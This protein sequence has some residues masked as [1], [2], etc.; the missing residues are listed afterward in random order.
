M[1]AVVLSRSKASS[2]GLGTTAAAWACSHFFDG[3]VLGAGPKKP[4][5]FVLAQLGKAPEGLFPTGG[6]RNKA[7]GVL[8]SRGCAAASLAQ[9][10]LSAAVCTAFF[11][12]MNYLAAL[13]AGL[14]EGALN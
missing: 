11:A 2:Y 7:Q 9:E 14:A 5:S 6:L 1:I 8:D 13:G 12:E 4:Y 3:R 10:Q